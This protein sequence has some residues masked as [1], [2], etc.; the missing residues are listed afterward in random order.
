M[1]P[2]V[3]SGSP[4][5]RTNRQVPVCHQ[6]PA[7]GRLS[8][9]GGNCRP[10]SATAPHPH[11]PPLRGAGGYELPDTDVRTS[12][13]IH[14]SPLG[15]RLSARSI[16]RPLPPPRLVPCAQPPIVRLVPSRSDSHG[17]F[18]SIFPMLRSKSPF[19]LVPSLLQRR[20]AYPPILHYAT[21]MPRRSSRRHEQFSIIILSSETIASHL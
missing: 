8:W 3:G 20:G 1:P 17:T 5:T 11:P 15:K 14:H 18:C 9:N 4:A 13:V 19:G 2:R 16:R 6:G 21:T 10:V 7:A 12:I